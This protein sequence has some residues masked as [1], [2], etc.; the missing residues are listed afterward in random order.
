MAQ[1]ARE[2]AA[3]ERAVVATG[4][5]ANAWRGTRMGLGVFTV[6]PGDVL[7]ITAC[8]VGAGDPH[9]HLDART[10]A[11]GMA[12]TRA[13]TAGGSDARRCVGLRWAAPRTA[14]LALALTAATGPP[15]LR[16]VALYVGPELRPGVTWPWLALVVALAMLVLAPSMS[17]PALRRPPTPGSL[18]YRP[19]T[20]RPGALVALLASFVASHLA[21][22][23][24]YRAPGAMP[25][26]ALYSGV[27][28][29][30]GF[31]LSA[32]WL[33]GGLSADGPPLRRALGLARAE[34]RWLL[35]APPIALGLLL[36]AMATAA[37][38]T[39]TSES[40]VA[41]AVASSPLRLV[42]L[43]TALLAPLSEELFYRGAVARA[44]DPAG[45]VR[46][47]V[48]QA[49]LFTLPHALQIRGAL[50]G[51]LPI[52]ALGLANGW[53]RRASGGIAAPWLVHSIYNGALI[54]A[55]AFGAG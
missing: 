23:Q 47:I 45:P 44:L 16:R 37:L 46:A 50:W 12:F 15:A 3:A 31:C 17:G 40:S 34:G 52:A 22:A 39:D 43:Y 25:A 19:V 18:I 49:A 32:A 28:L 6:R 29:H 24:A 42:L 27:A 8:P 48:L 55:A 7:R 41:Q 4:A 14:T 54:V 20:D 36:V 1:H 26:P 10:P 30:L 5:Q 35:R 11:G 38:I 53:L 2:L 13:L 33:L 51:L 9:L 21:A